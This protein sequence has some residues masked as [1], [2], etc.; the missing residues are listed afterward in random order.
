MRHDWTC[1]GDAPSRAAFTMAAAST[2]A[3][4][5]AAISADP[6]LRAILSN[7]RGNADNYRMWLAIF[8]PVESVACCM[9]CGRKGSAVPRHTPLKIMNLRAHN[10][11]IF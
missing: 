9:E 1:F 7:A 11:Y 3:C 6:P 4:F 10:W 5:N 2:S 8:K